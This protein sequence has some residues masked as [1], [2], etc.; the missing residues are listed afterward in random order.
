MRIL[1]TTTPGRGHHLPMVGLARAF[2]DKGHEVGWAGHSSICKSFVKRGFEAFEAGLP[3][4]ITSA[5]LDERYP[6]IMALPPSERPSFLFA[7]IFGPERAGPMLEDL[8]PIVRDFRPA[9]LVCDQAELA[10][11]IAAAVAGV[12]NVTHSF[13]HPLPEDRVARASE[14]MNGLWED[15][16]LEPSQYAGTYEY[17]YL[18]IYPESLKMYASPH[19]REV[20]PVRPA[21]AAGRTDAESRWA[22]DGDPLVYITF[23]TVWNTDFKLISTVVEGVSRLPVR[24][25]LTCGP[26]NDPALLGDQPPNV[27]V[28]EFIPQA[29]LL[30]HCAAVVSHAG[31][32]T[33]LAALAHGLPQILL[34]QAAD[35]FLNAAAGVRAGVGVAIQS[36]VLSSNALADA[37]A[38]LLGDSAQR[39]AAQA[40]A[41]EIDAM[42]SYDQV[43]EAIE[44]RF[45]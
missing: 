32:G 2:R 45:T 16:G 8:L 14:E 40:V 25:V 13:G 11:P 7:K 37:L 23:G 17:P 6:D 15:H 9:L 39:E 22:G 27:E 30:P 34:P 36:E 24:V 20:Q 10:G 19:I 28:A 12:P 41:A 44:R 26:G 1:F 31:S 38:A 5:G 4:G 18:D 33:F 21:E 3:E 42:A 43:A 29:D 35:Q